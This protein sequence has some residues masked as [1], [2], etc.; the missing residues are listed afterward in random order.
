MFTSY[1]CIF[2]EGKGLCADLKQAFHTQTVRPWSGPM[3]TEWTEI[4]IRRAVHVENDP[5]IDRK[6]AVFA[7]INRR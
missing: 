6:A 5:G 4:L 1:T 7:V 2:F 3:V